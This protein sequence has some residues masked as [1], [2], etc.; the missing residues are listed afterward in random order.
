MK[1]NNAYEA[2]INLVCERLHKWACTECNELLEQAVKCQNIK[3]GGANEKIANYILFFGLF[4]LKQAV[5]C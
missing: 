1:I 3:L 5:V 2:T 4:P